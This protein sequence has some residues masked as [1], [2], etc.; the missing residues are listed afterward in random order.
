M[1]GICLVL[2]YYL[3]RIDAKIQ[4]T[5][6]PVCT[7]YARILAVPILQHDTANKTGKQSLSGRPLFSTP[8]DNGRFVAEGIWSFFVQATAQLAV[9]DLGCGR[10]SRQV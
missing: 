10:D 2:F 5:L 7:E 1:A 8:G 4:T 9:P 6:Q 3:W